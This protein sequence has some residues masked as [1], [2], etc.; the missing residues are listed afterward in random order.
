[1]GGFVTRE[2]L[3]IGETDALQYQLY[4]TLS[5]VTF[6]WNMFKV[7]KASGIEG[8]HQLSSNPTFVNGPWSV[9]A[10]KNK[11]TKKK[12]SVFIFNKKQFESN[13]SRSGLLNNRNRQQILSDCFNVLQQ[14]VANLVKF[15]HPNILNVLEPLEDHKSK[16]LFVTE[17]VI[18]DLETFTKERP[19]DTPVEEIIVTK[20][21]LQ[22][23]NAIK[24]LH[25]NQNLCHLNI[26]PNTILITEN[27]DWKLSG[28]SFIQPCDS[29][30]DFFLDTFDQRMPKFTNVSFRF[31]SPNLI[32]NHKLDYSNDLFSLG[33]LIHYLFSA[34]YLLH[35]DNTFQ[36]YETEIKRLNYVLRSSSALNNPEFRHIPQSHK[37]LTMLLLNQQ[38]SSDNAIELEDSVTINTVISDQIFQSELIKILN[39]VDELQ[40]ATVEEKCIFLTTLKAHLHQFPKTL[41]LNKFVPLLTSTLLSP[42]L[43]TS[44]SK[45]NQASKIQLSA[46]DERLIVLSLENLFLASSQISQ[47]SFSEN[48]FPYLEQVLLL[49]LASANVALAKGIPLVESK[50]GLPSQSSYKDS[51]T[52][53]QVSLFHN[54]MD[55]SEIE[56]QEAVLSTLIDF[57]KYQPYHTISQKFL[58]MISEQFAKTTSF[59]VKNLTIHAFITLITFE[60]N[61]LDDFVIVE[62]ILPIVQATSVKNF[63]NVSILSNVINLYHVM[64]VKLSETLISFGSE[65][66]DLGVIME[67]VLFELWKLLRYVPDKK[68]AA[69][70]KSILDQIQAFVFSKAISSLPEEI[71]KKTQPSQRTKDDTEFGD[72]DSNVIE[73]RQRH[74]VAPQDDLLDS[75]QNKN[76]PSE[77]IHS[78][79][80]PVVPSTSTILKPK[81]PLVLRPNKPSPN[82]TLE[83]KNTVSN[84]QTPASTPQIDWSASRNATSEP[85]AQKLP[86]GFSAGIIQPNRVKPK[87]K[88]NDQRLI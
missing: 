84:T 11:S 14:Y 54:S 52:K 34:K 79:F 69:N 65:K 51:Y 42:Y 77:N 29:S 45:K 6:S 82:G 53:F 9:Y 60:P 70:L 28:F 43:S 55:T 67:R 63:N 40:A 83:V 81:T 44:M 46:E 5:H 86:P 49:N 30:K 15:K 17:Y 8:N 58:P 62:K 75:T 74:V 3:D 20:G 32:L 41:L 18:S 47:L 7:F 88:T 26:Q 76:L 25:E 64:F 57:I 10:A 59:K 13:L 71:P 35:T 27:F 80:V 38:S 36:E 61:P 33:L 31:S 19:D 85:E 23:S 2:K 66:M 16:C 1:M 37:H 48:V 21:L 24:F 50:L 22:V 87:P 72:F 39:F 12:C 56:P 78:N 68:E 4:N 73:S